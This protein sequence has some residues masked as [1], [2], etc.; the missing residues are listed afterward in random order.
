MAR[1]MVIEW[2]MGEKTGLVAYDLDG[3]SPFLGQRPLEEPGRVYSEATAERVDEEVEPVELNIT[4][5]DKPQT[6][7]APE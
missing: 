6:E 4:D 7:Q 2:G 5:K 3:A 1:R